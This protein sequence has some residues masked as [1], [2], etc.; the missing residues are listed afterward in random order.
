MSLPHEN[1]QYVR[2]MVLPSGHAIDVTCFET[3]EPA[4]AARPP[5]P[6]ADLRICPECDRDLVYPVEWHEASDSH[7]RVLLRCP[8]C[9]WTEF[10]VHDQETVDLFDELLDDATETLARELR[11]LEQS[12]MEDEIERLRRALAADALLPEDF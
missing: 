1:D 4:A 11:S 3:P 2:R 5:E 10:D 7:W 6:V 9:E 12:N 8:N